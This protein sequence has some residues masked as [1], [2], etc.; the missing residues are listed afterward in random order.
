MDTYRKGKEFE[1]EV[2][3]IFQNLIDDDEF[4][5]SKKRCKIFRGKSYYSRDRDSYI[6]FDISIEVY[7]PGSSE[8][9]LLFLIE[10]KDYLGAIPVNDA[11][12]FLSKM[13][14]VRA[15]KGIIASRNSFQRSTIAF[16]RS[17]GIGLIRVLEKS[18]IKWELH[19]SISSLIT[20]DS[21]NSFS[22]L[23]SDCIH[24]EEIES[25]LFDIVFCTGS[26]FTVSFRQFIL[27]YF[28]DSETIDILGNSVNILTD[29]KCLVDWVNAQEIEMKATEI[30]KEIHYID[31][32]VDLESI[33]DYAKG[34]F[35]LNV[36]EKEGRVL[37][38]SLGSIKFSPPVITLWQDLGDDLFRRRFTLAHE[39][40]HL[41][42][43][44]GRY[45]ISERVD[46][47]DFNPED[48]SSKSLRMS[49]KEIRRIE[50]QANQ[51][52]S[53]LLLPRSQF[54]REV[55]QICQLLRIEDKGYGLLYLDNQDCNQ[56]AFSRVV[57]HIKPRFSVSK[58]VIK[59]RLK[60][61]GLLRE[62][63]QIFGQLGASSTPRS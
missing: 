16:S 15:T 35:G 14:Q 13:R 36:I 7:N 60:A 10:C 12:E 59:I 57:S 54:E 55:K 32:K 63:Q 28:S 8:P 49:I 31:G 47:N 52:A 11:E 33:C 45:L 19:R 46:E 50:W 51:F 6:E 58:R 17:N 62:P 21:A 2:F 3:D 22:N 41:F 40:G 9:A 18:A 25:S 5:C 42:L 23:A 44:H 48:S 34:V 43:D 4:I 56:E 26:L 61:L 53:C 24:N 39:L 38:Q 37:G 1:D 27:N 20:A 29:E 30:L